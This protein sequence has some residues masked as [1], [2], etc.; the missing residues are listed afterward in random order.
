MESPNQSLGPF[1]KLNAV[2]H[3]EVGPG[4][5]LLI[6]AILA[7]TIMNSS[8]AS[9]YE[10][11]FSTKVVLG[12]G[13][14]I[15]DK[16]FLLWV[17]DG[18]MA[19]FFFL[20][21]LE[22]KRELMVGHLSDIRQ[23][24]LPLGAAVGGMAAP[25]L[26]YLIITRDVEG[27]VNGWAIP[28]ATDI[29]FAVGV[30]ALLGPR[31]PVAL[32]VFLL[33]LAVADDL[34]AIVIIAIF[35]TDQLSIGALSVAFAALSV[36]ILMNRLN[37]G[38]Q[39]AYLF[40]GFIMWVAV[41][42]SGV[43]ATLAGVALGFCIPYSLPKQES[44]PVVKLEHELHGFSSYIVLPLFAFANAGVAIGEQ[45]LSILGHPVPLGIAGGLLIGKPIGVMIFCYFILKFGI[46]SMPRHVNW[47]QL[48]GVA[49]LCGI[50]FT[51]SLFIGSLAFGGMGNPLAGLDR[52]GIL[53]G[54]IISA[55][56]G[57]V[58][59]KKALPDKTSA[60]ST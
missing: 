32:K 33:T 48:L 15:I 9:Y 57:F 16:P 19:I 17:N 36:L 41:L 27:A 37:V 24:F 29:A 54:S 20:I 14:I 31:V 45:G 40:I 11:V 55:V 8:L 39:S 35:Y 10:D 42:K 1:K 59:L 3:S 44:S 12:V 58:V 26:I 43:H 4:V 60:D 5:L 51:M 49:F 6:M 21:G 53:T 22:I 30:L 47:G 34:G 52:L 25:A 7:M 46:A 23:A 38:N 28:A 56:V 18:L 50:G 13:P 2:L